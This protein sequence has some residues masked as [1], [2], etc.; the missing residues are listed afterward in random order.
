MKKV[1]VVICTVTT[2]EGKTEECGE[3]QI[4]EFKK[5]TVGNTK[6]KIKMHDET[7]RENCL[8]G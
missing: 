4:W 1:G 6:V 2:P 3:S 7:M 5:G 8:N